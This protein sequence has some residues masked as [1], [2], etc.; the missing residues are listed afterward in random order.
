MTKQDQLLTTRE[1]A[2]RAGISTPSVTKMIKAGKITAEKKSGKWMIPADQLKSG[3][4][5]GLRAPAKPGAKKKTAE[6]KPP[7]SEKQKP[8][9][10]KT[11]AGKTYSIAEFAA[12]TYLTPWGGRISHIMHAARFIG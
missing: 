12:M 1:F 11:S 3:D 5:K 4:V 2:A 9:Q 10:T 6:K 8:T 7:A